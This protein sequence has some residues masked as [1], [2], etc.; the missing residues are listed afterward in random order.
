MEVG[1]VEQKSV[2][3]LPQKKIERKEE[4][5]K[6]VETKEVASNSRNEPGKGE[7]ANFIA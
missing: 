4:E 5:K 2:S 6:D 3:S 7:K 1:A